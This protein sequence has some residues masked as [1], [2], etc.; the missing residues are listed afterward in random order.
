MTF[1]LSPDQRALRDEIVALA[2]ELNVDARQRD[3]N[4]QFDREL[5]RRS[6]ACGIQGLPVPAEFGGRGLTSLDTVVALEA[7]GYGCED[8]GLVFALCAHLL[9]G[10]VPLWKHGDDQQRRRLLPGWCDGSLIAANAM[11]EPQAGS[12]V[13]SITLKAERDGAGHRLTGTKTFI[14]NAAVAD[15]AIVF[16]VTDSAKGFH[17]GLTAFLL[18]MSSKGVIR[19]ASFNTVGVRSCAIGEIHLS[20]AFVP[21]GMVL[22]GVGGGSAVFN[23][24]MEWERGCL[25][26]AHVGAMERLLET[27]IRRVRSRKQFAQSIGKFQ[28][29]AHRVADMKVELDAARLL[30]WRSAWRL[31]NARTAALEA[32]IT[33]L[34]VS[35]AFLRV[36]IDAIRT[37]GGQGLL[38]E[39]DVERVTRDALAGV[40][41]SGTSDIQRNII[42][43][44]LGL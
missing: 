30:T 33:K 13:F 5:W 40:I 18:D 24:A 42:A 28:A 12:D 9:A 22:G 14:T 37:F 2:R 41:Y 43:R 16:A 6:A 1:D 8:G 34:F 11:T 3:R 32:S 39:H 21:D 25:F 17:G 10:V 36:S 19:S 4:R 15:W 29:V 31:Q 7:L 20:E 26:A 35:E 38:E 23:T 44:W 27:V